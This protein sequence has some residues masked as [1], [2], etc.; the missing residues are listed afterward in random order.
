[1]PKE[2]S[3]IVLDDDQSSRETL[4]DFLR[5]HSRINLLQSLSSSRMAIRNLA[6]FK[7]DILFLKT[8][9]PEKTG[10]DIQKEI[11]ELKLSTQIIFISAHEEYV[12][13]AF[14]NGAFDYL[15]KP[16]TKI[17]FNDSVNRLLQKLSDE[18]D[19]KKDESIIQ[20]DK[21]NC[22][23]M[24][25]KDILIKGCDNSI[26]LKADCIFYVQADS[27]FTNIHLVSSK[28]EVLSKNLGT[29]EF[30][31]AQT[32]FYKISRSTII[33]TQYVA[34]IDRLKSEITLSINEKR[35]ILKAS[36]GQLLDLEGFISKQQ[37]FVSNN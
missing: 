19:S 11:N 29:Y 9:M 16:I 31:F 13:E 24:R 25:N 37:L 21:S 4:N 36:V 30:Y 5:D 20:K 6:T 33:N 10:L 14:K 12:M 2:F 7:P 22:C 17:D 32:P 26:R 34:K 18:N 3:C 1:M 8:I 15:V 23:A 28:T 27:G 35:I